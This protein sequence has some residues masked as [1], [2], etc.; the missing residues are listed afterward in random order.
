[1]I[2][3]N[4]MK[5]ML[6]SQRESYN[7]LINILTKNFESKFQNLHS[8]VSNLKTEIS[9]LRRLDQ[10]KNSEIE[11]LKLKLNNLEAPVIETQTAQEGYIDRL[12]YIEDQS[13]INNLRFDGVQEDRAENWEVSTSKVTKI[14]KEKLGIEDEIAIDRA[15]RVGKVIE[16]KP[17]TIL[18]K[19]KNFPDRANIIKN[20]RKLKGSNIYINE[21]LCERSRLKRKALL[22]EL[23]SLREQGKIAY[24]SGTKII[25]KDKPRDNFRSGQLPP[26]P[27]NPPHRR[28][29]SDSHQ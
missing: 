6:Q 9:E 14:I 24:F 15:Y 20:S 2:S 17:R 23:K 22:P 28:L 3:K 10:E 8:E 18:V 1:M 29:R 19:L 5:S 27:S 13:R 21:D 26:L 4:E 12:D 16:N 11:N 7:D 25:S